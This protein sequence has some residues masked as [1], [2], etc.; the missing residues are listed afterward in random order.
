MN[1]NVV[2]PAR[3]GSTRLPDKVIR[4]IAGQPM[5]A[6]VCNQAGRS[7]AERVVVATDDADIA[8]IGTAAQATVAMTRGDHSCGTDRIA[9]A[10]TDLQWAD[11]DIVVNVQADEPLMP[12]ALINQ[13]A[14]ALNDHPQ[15]QMATACTPI[16][17]TAEL[18]N[19]NIVKVVCDRQDRALYF[20][21]APIPYHRDSNNKTLSSAVARHLGIYAYRV[22][23]LK[24]FAA[25]PAGG[26]EQIESLEQLRA[27]DLGMKIQLVEAEQVP[28]PG[29]DTEADLAVVE[30]LLLA[31]KC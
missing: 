15:A 18:Q 7:G 22:G 23:A 30:Q 31:G 16:T 2:I 1:F 28:G 24:R 6:H 29:V 21:R 20:S 14:Q 3:R 26:L 4:P 8:A 10:V 9:Q 5:V 17:A 13:V 11:D 27:Y 19:P 25:A 12:P